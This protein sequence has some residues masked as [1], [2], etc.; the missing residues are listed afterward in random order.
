MKIEDKL[1]KLFHE[2]L[3]QG[4]GA[5]PDFQ[6]MWEEAERSHRRKQ[7]LIWKIAASLLLA[8]TIGVVVLLSHQDD[9]NATIIAI[10]LWNEP[11][12]SLTVPQSGL[13]ISELTIWKS[14]TGFLLPKNNQ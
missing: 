1:K 4:A 14:P 5:I 10:T 12:K 13:E 9:K 2:N 7:H 11:T 3:E 6:P 8:G